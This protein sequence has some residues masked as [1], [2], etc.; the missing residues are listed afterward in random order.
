MIVDGKKSKKGICK[1]K[2]AARPLMTSVSDDEEQ[3][4]PDY[5]APALPPPLKPKPGIPLLVS[6]ASVLYQ[7]TFMRRS[8]IIIIEWTDRLSVGY[9]SLI[10]C[11]C[12][13]PGAFCAARA[14]PRPRRWPPWAT[15]V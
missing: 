14:R 1:P 7:T 8:H 11:V 13:P 3:K 6:Q 5:L 2:V 4:P 10:L 9:L 12:H 15:A